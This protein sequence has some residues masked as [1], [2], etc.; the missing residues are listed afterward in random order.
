LFKPSTGFEDQGPL[1]LSAY[2]PGSSEQQAKTWA[3]CLALL[4]QKTPD[5]A[6]IIEAWPTLPLALRAGILAMIDA[7]REDV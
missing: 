2:T 4:T 5:L 7:A 1:T 3:F 6:R